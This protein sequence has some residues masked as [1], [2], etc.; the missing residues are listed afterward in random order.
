VAVGQDPGSVALNEAFFAGS[1]DYV[2]QV[3]HLD[4]YRYIRTAITREVAGIERLLDVGNGGVFE[5]DTSQVGE[6][7]AVDLFLESLPPARFPPNVTPRDG[8]ALALAEPEES[9]DGVLTAFL[10]HHL[11]GATPGALVDN[12]RR[13]IAECHRMLKPG[14]TF[15]VGESCVAPWFYAV[16]RVMFRPLALLANRTPVLGHPATLQ[17]PFDLLEQLVA[18]RFE[19]VRGY[20]IRTGRWL[21]QFGRRWPSLLTPARPYLIAARKPES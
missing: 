7:V 4:T 8:D 15:V 10:F 12:V 9:F 16:E 13:S 21:S 14:G 20:P 2:E 18:E 6:I 17:L 5:Y 11:V 3:T 1:E 19:I